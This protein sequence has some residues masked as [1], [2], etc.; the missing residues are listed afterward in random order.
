MNRR[1]F[2][3]AAGA[4]AFV[5]RRVAANDKVTIAMIG[6]NGRART[7]AKWFGALPDV[8]IPIV[9]DVDRNV[10][11]PVMKM[12]AESQG[13]DPV[14]QSDIR[15][16]LDDK[17]V[18][19]VVMATPIHWHAAGTI[20]ACDAGKDVYVEKPTSHNVREGRWMVEAARRNK[21]IV[22]H[23]TQSRSRPVAEH[24]VEVCRS[25]KLGKVLMAKVMDCQMRRSI[26]HVE[27]EPVPAGIDYDAWTGP[28][29]MMPFNRNRF[30]GTVN[31][32]WH[33]GGGDMINDSVH[34]VDIA[35]WALGVDYPTEVS[36]MGRKLYFDDDQQTPDTM[37]ITFNYPDK[38]IQY[39]HRLWNPYRLEG[40]ENTVAAYGTEGYAQI[41]RWQG[42]HY[43]LRVFDAKGKLLESDREPQPETTYHARNFIDC[44]KSRK[45]PNADVEVGHI[46]SATCHLGNIVARTGKP[47]KF[48]GR[49]EAIVGDA[50]LSRYLD[51]VYRK[52]WSTPKQGR[53]A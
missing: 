27:D 19:A 2:F 22:Q 4:S 18:D 39:E 35:R 20:L 7:L 42:G 52:H 51:R 40:S 25:G 34:F 26:G 1:Y 49:S 8:R 48:D 21:R 11:G 5:P 6:I 30:H 37:N 31:W 17:S 3:M 16:V 29:P 32:H 47:L 43:E 36:G 10:V 15:R 45:T 13:K 38:V 53:T 9:C 12:V 33:Y 14:L 44:V 41:G 50:D 46:S 24:F 23:G 28:V